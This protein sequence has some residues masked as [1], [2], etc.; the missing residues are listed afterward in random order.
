MFVAYTAKSATCSH[1]VLCLPAQVTGSTGTGKTALVESLR[2]RVKTDYFVSGKFNLMKRMTPYAAIVDALTALAR[3]LREEDEHRRGILRERLGPEATEVIARCV[4]AM[5]EILMDDGGGDK[6]K[7]LAARRQSQKPGSTESRN[8]FNFAF[9]SLLRRIC[10]V[11]GKALVLFIDDLQC[12]CEFR[13]GECN[14]SYRGCINANLTNQ[15]SLV[16]RIIQG[17]MQHRSN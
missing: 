9:R 7:K 1:L 4:P 11:N 8:Q 15:F 17:Q 14:S 13:G 6:K 10:E 16:P 5:K 3:E 12:E 2:S